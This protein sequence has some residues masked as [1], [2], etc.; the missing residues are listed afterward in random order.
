VTDRGTGGH[1]LQATLAPGV[2]LHSQLHADDA[3]G[4]QVVGFRAH[5]GHSQFPG[6][7]HGLREDLKLGVLVPPADLQA[8]VVDRGADDEAERLESG[9]AEQHILR[10]RQVRGENPRR[11]GSG[12]LREPAVGY[13]RLPHPRTLVLLV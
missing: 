13:L 12:R 6:A 1:E 9:L 2:H 4:G 10:Y 11:T 7:V 3:V 5:P 8:D